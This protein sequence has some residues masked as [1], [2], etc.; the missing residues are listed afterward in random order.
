MITKEWLHGI[1][2]VKISST[3][4]PEKLIEWLS[5]Q[6]IPL[7]EDDDTPFDWCYSWDYERFVRKL[8]V[9]D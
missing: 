8:P 4:D 2:V 9:I 7:V 6:T 3:P 5:G 1:K